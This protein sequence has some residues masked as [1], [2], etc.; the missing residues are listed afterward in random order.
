MPET[1]AETPHETAPK[2]ASF[3]TGLKVA[4]VGATGGLGGALADLL[5][6]NPAVE[7]VFR[8]A[9]RPAAEDGAADWLRL[10]LE[11]EASMAAAAEAIGGALH[12]AIVA[13][14]ILHDGSVLRPEKTLRQL[15]A[16]TMERVFRINS[17]GPALVAKHLLPL[18]PRDRKSVFAALS[19]RVGSIADN[20][21]GGWYGY[22]AS[23][24]ALNMLIRTLAI[25]LARR[26][27]EAVCV[28]LHPGTVDSGLSA[29]F[30]SAVPDG[31]LFR[32]R[33]AAHHL[34]TV[35]DGLTAG[36]SGK[37][38]AWDGSVIPY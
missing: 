23:K 3:G 16:A 6:A 11:D 12:I 34:L 2:L 5:E 33:R 4:V 37:L 21:L 14:G 7:R 8:L 29:P 36:D 32:P 26:N 25:E 20:E 15:D 24:A 22:R 38:F 30:Q 13:T 10:D 1:P 27:G 17:I 18:L 28:G 19:A 35:L 9:R 31:G